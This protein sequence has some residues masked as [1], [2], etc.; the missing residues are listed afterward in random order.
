MLR[1]GGQIWAE[2]DVG[3]GA[4]FYFTLGG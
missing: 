3:Q 4:R 2:G 1:H